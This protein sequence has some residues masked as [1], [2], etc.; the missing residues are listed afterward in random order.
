MKLTSDSRGVKK[1]D[2]MWLH[3]QA[4]LCKAFYVR[5]SEAST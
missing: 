1:A 5:E 3:Q 4:A 2:K